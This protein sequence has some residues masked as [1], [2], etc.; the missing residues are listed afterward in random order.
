[1]K[2]VIGIDVG[3]TFTDAVAADDAGNVIGA[4]TPST[5]A[6]YSIGVLAAISE[7]D[8]KSVV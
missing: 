2:Y 5:P 3:G 7:L 6:D 4:K 1:M 8:R